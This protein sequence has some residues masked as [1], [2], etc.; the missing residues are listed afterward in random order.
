[1]KRIN[2][3]VFGAAALAL[4]LPV[5]AC[6]SS[7]DEEK[8]AASIAK[9]FQEEGEEGLSLTDEEAQCVGDGMVSEVGAEELQEYNLL[10][11][12]FEATEE[13]DSPKMSDEDAD[14]AATVFQ[15]CADVKGL[16]LEGLAG[17]DLPDEAQQCVEDAITD[18]RVHDFLTA[19]FQ[20]DAEAGQEAF[21]GPITECMVAG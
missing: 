14:K 10:N 8:A 17:E 15:D 16:M 12:D 21:A 13:T 1:M 7:A 18:E 20:D 19:L 5:S 9:Q 3:R 4:V 11:E 6:G 2:K